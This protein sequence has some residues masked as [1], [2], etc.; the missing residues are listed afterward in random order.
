MDLDSIERMTNSH[1][2][3]SSEASSNQILSQETGRRI[4]LAHSSIESKTT[5]LFFVL[6]GFVESGKW[7]NR[8]L[9]RTLSKRGGKM[10][11]AVGEI[12]SYCGR[13]EYPLVCLRKGLT[14]RV[15]KRLIS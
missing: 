2:T 10:E 4:S 12:A 8:L 5:S 7:G 3:N 1:N 14:N 6:Y 15:G 9:R 11:L 13:N